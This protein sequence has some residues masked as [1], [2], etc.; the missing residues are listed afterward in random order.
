MRMFQ[1]IYLHVVVEEPVVD[2]PVVVVE[3]D[4]VVDPVVDLVADVVVDELVVLLAEATT[5][6]SQQLK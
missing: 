1:S 4:V 2:D 6:T 3:V 5:V